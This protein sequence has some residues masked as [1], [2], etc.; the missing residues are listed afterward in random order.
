MAPCWPYT[1]SLG[2]LSLVRNA[3]LHYNV[4]MGDKVLFMRVSRQCQVGPAW[5]DFLKCSIQEYY[6][7][8]FPPFL[9]LNVENQKRDMINLLDQREKRNHTL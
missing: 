4:A 5:A 1:W 9:D 7:V 3:I 6:G 8:F 2:I